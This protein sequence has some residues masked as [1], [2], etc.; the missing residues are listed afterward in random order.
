MRTI[1]NPLLFIAVM[2]FATSCI[3]ENE[4]PPPVNE[5]DEAAY[6]ILR[7]QM[8]DGFAG[9]RTRSTLSF[10]D[11]NTITG[12]T[13]LV[14]DTENRLVGIRPGRNVTSDP[15]SGVGR[16]EV[17]L[18][19]S[20]S[21]T[22]L[23]RLVVVAN[24]ADIVTARLGASH[25]SVPDRN[26]NAVMAALWSGID[27]K[28]FQTE[29]LIPMWG[30]LPAATSDFPAQGIHIAEGA[31]I[32]IP[33]QL[34]RSIARIDV[35]VGTV[36]PRNE[37]HEWTGKNLAG[38]V[39]P[40][41]LR[42]VHVARPNNRFAVAPHGGNVQFVTSNGVP[43]LPTAA[44]A[45]AFGSFPFLNVSNAERDRFFFSTPELSVPITDNG[46]TFNNNAFRRQIYVPEANILTPFGRNAISNPRSGDEH[47]LYRMALIIGG[48]YR[49]GATTYYRV[50]FVSGGGLVNVLR[51]HLYRVNIMGVS[52]PGESTPEEAYRSLAMRMDVEIMDWVQDTQE[53]FFDG[54]NWIRLHN[55]RNES[56]SRHAIL[57]RTTNTTDELR[58]ETTIPLDQWDMNGAGLGL[59][60]GGTVVAPDPD[61]DTTKGTLLQTVANARFRVEMIATHTEIELVT[62]R[63]IHHGFFRFTSLADYVSNAANNPST[64]RVE[65]GRMVGTSRIIHFPITISQHGEDPG[66]WW[67]GPGTDL[68]LGDDD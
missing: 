16:F 58:F 1:L 54:V 40:F 21:P 66:D 22:D 19:A 60:H 59:S 62:G 23:F 7:V 6:V 17:T 65:A 9:Q 61:F 39:I 46:T 48:G 43:S 55:T 34:H 44:G 57:Y 37:D 5:R 10:D 35:G 25:L 36:V 29:K 26:Y 24:A 15:E 38:D 3:S 28:M 8:P 20:T 68:D 31:T 18:L 49:G 41:E 52:G 51:N 45:P 11:E 27:G 67:E 4:L 53:T 32:A 64:L 33:V 47:H 63:T 42:S 12:M 50:D 14:F 2:T 13:V 30:Q 56:L